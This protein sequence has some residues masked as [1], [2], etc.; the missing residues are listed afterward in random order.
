MYKQY[1]IAIVIV[2]M[3]GIIAYFS[4]EKHYSK[5]K[6]FLVSNNQPSLTKRNLN[7]TKFAKDNQVKKITI[8]S[9]PS[10]Y[11]PVQQLQQTSFVGTID[12]PTMDGGLINNSD[13]LPISHEEPNDSIKTISPTKTESITTQPK[14]FQDE[15]VTSQ[16]VKDVLH[17]A[18]RDGKLQ[19]VLNN[20]ENQ[21]LPA[22]LA[23]LPIVESQ[24]QTQILS[25]KGAGGDWQLMP[26]VAKQYGI[27]NQER[28]QFSSST[29]VAL[30]LLINLHH[31][32]KNW[33]LTFAAYNAGSGRIKNAL[34]K[35]P[36]AHDINDLDIPNETKQYVNRIKII[37][38]LLEKNI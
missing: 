33:N 10:G 9:I 14:S 19:Y 7:Q 24:Y 21:G 38:D 12:H 27:T 5:A 3:L 26:S 28:F 18:A 17:K 16:K 1:S 20:T 37:N 36:N 2:M 23:I 8:L 32:F 34:A 30:K 11:R 29:D 22:S 31:Q 13:G 35:N 6:I 4:F 25:A 15:W